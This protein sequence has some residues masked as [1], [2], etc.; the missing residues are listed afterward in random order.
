M[1]TV[2]GVA[3]TATRPSIAVC[4]RKIISVERVTP[5][6]DVDVAEAADADEVELQRAV[7][8]VVVVVDDLRQNGI[9]MKAE[10]NPIVVEAR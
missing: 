7:E 6:V 4:P 3:F 2:I 5:R 8:D 1:E 9:L 10:I